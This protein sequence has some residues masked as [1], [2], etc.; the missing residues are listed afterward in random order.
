MKKFLCLAAAILFRATLAQAGPTEIEAKDL[1][2]PPKI[3]DANDWHF[4]LG[5]P[6]WL[7]GASG[8]IGL[9]G[10][11]KGVDVDFSEI[12]RHIDWA[13][14]ISGELRKGRFGVYADLL[15]LEDSA[16]I[17]NNG[18]LSKVDIA[19]SEYIV[20]GEVF[21]RIY[22][23][24]RGHIDL[25]AGG[26]YFDT[27]SS[28]KLF[29]NSRE[30]DIAAT[31]LANALDSDLKELLVRLLKHRLD[32]NDPPLPIPPL[33]A[34]EKL[35]LLKKIH[36]ARQDPATAQMKIA[37]VLNNQLNRT[38]AITERW[39]DPY[40]GIGGRYDLTKTFYLTGKGD[41]GGFGVASDITA[42]GYAGVGCQITRDLYVEAGYRVL[43]YDYDS[44]GFLFKTTTKGAQ[45]TVG[46]VF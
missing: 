16:A 20:N 40:I 18:M 44:D 43:Y 34:G 24:P 39:A 13:V 21:Y 33:T 26:R 37:Q 23:A 12:L 31:K 6:G 42:Q 32:G 41:I 45:I 25:R 7:A 3:A 17:Y 10:V 36:N 46:Y 30:I 15:Y 5:I 1:V 19:I 38:F 11:T 8:D 14:S 4:N 22:E 29:G 28:S 27:Y 2:V 9:H 35:E